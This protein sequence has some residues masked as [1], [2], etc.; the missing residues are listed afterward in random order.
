MPARLSWSH[1]L[2]GIVALAVVILLAGGVLKY[3][4]V[5]RV[6]GEKI[7]IYML[8]NQARGIMRGSDVW[9]GGQK[10]GI[11]DDIQ[12]RAPSTDSSG[13]VV[14]SLRVRARDAAQIRRDSRPQVRAGANMIGPIVVYISA[15]SSESPAVKAGDT[16]RGVAQSDMEVAGTKVNAATEQLPFIMADA[17]TVLRRVHDRNGTVG[18]VMTEGVAS[19]IASLRAQVTR[20][21]ARLAARTTPVRGPALM[22]Q[23]HSVMSRVDSVKTLLASPSVAFGRFRRDSTLL[24]TVGDLRDELDTLRVALAN[25]EGSVGRLKTD[26]ALVRS[27]ANAR[28]EMAELFADMRRR[29]LHYVN[30]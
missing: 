18:A 29:P 3:A 20:L 15:G 13:R 10:I 4:G 6:R 14:L 16:L 11:V 21:R 12:F 17:R 25:Q 24:K 22:A 9:V 26:S 5:G 2:P 19:D 23:A 8:T 30:F 28:A 1:L 7:N 27:V